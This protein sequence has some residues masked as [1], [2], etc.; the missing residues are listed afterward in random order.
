MPAGVAGLLIAAIFSAAMSSLDSAINSSS[1]VIVT[2]LQRRLR[3][4]KTE[5]AYLVL[6]RTLYR[7]PRIVWNRCCSLSGNL[8][9]SLSL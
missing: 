7:P 1:A 5:H 8:R 3:P 9:V 2:D 6:G 4:P